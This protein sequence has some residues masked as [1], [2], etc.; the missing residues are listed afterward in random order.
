MIKT[1]HPYPTEKG[2]AQGIIPWQ[3]LLY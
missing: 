2:L 3:A 1:I